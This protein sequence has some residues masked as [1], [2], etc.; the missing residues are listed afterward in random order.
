VLSLCIIVYSIFIAKNFLRI[1]S[2]SDFPLIENGAL[3]KPCW[4]SDSSTNRQNDSALRRPNVG[5]EDRSSTTDI[6]L[7][8]ILCTSTRKKTKWGSYQLRCRD[9]KTWAQKCTKDVHIVTDI[10]FEDMQR[11]RWL[12]YLFGQMAEEEK[13][14]YNS[15]IFVKS[16]PGRKR[17]LPLY[18]NMFIDMVDEYGYFD[19]D[20]PPEMHLILQTDLQGRQVFPSHNHTVV[21]HWY[22]SFPADMDLSGPPEYV[23][24]VAHQ[25]NISVATVWNTKRGKVPTEGGCPEIHSPNVSYEC[26]DQPFDI[27]TWY[28]KLFTDENDRCEMEKTLAN[29]RLGSGMLYYNVF[30]RYD[31]LVVLAKNDSMKLEYGNV[32]RAVSQMRSGVPV[33]IEIRGSVLEDFAE[34]YNYTCTFQ[35][36]HG[37]PTSKRFAERKEK[38]SSFDDAIELLQRPEIR[39]QCQEEGLAI[40]NDYSPSTIAQ[41]Y[42]RAVG[43]SGDFLC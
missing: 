15:T 11:L 17:F 30:R 16:F 25:S 8:R 1:S 5:Q 40:V 39:K 19:E 18:G 23:P 38:Y 34:R 24:P 32:Q 13:I 33:L 22:N 42:L 14:Q 3:S 9:L 28:L 43:Y 35:R 41:K 21:E 20:I 10:S 36:Y 6:D 2:K 31:A 26:L 37:D 7:F 27:S 29:P 4:L 12:R